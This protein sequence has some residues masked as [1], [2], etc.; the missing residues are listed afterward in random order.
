MSVIRLIQSDFGVRDLFNINEA[1]L[2]GLEEQ[3]SSDDD[4]DCVV[5]VEL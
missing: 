5:C 4:V 2:S 3:C 1:P